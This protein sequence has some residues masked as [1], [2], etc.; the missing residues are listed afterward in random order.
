M[1][2]PDLL[3]RG[4]QLNAGSVFECSGAPR[5]LWTDPAVSWAGTRLW[6][7]L[8]GFN[9]ASRLGRGNLPSV[10]ERGEAAIQFAVL[11]KRPNTISLD[12]N[13][14]VPEMGVWPIGCDDLDTLTGLNDTFRGRGRHRLCG[15]RQTCGPYVGWYNR[16]RISPPPPPESLQYGTTGNRTAAHE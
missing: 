14:T 7:H 2:L 8:A 12:L 3:L 11:P 4:S 15:I 13:A 10:V 16:I 1:V 5:S 6:L 9:D